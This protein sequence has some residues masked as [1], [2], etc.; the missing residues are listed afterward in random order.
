MPSLVNTPS[1]SMAA[2]PWPA[3]SRLSTADATRSRRSRRRLDQ[4]HVRRRRMVA[5]AL[6][7]EREGRLRDTVVG[8]GRRDTARGAGG[9]ARDP[10]RQVVG[11]AAGVHQQNS[12]QP[13]R[14]GGQQPF[15]QLDGSLLQVAAVG[16]ERGQLGAD[17]VD[18]RRV[19][20][21]QHGHVV[22]G[23]EVAAPVRPLE[24]HPSS[25]HEMHRLGVAE[26]EP[27]QQV[28]ACAKKL[29][30][31]SSAVGQP[32]TDV[33]CAPRAARRD[34]G[35]PSCQRVQADVEHGLELAVRLVADLR[36]EALLAGSA[37]R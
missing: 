32:A 15:G 5:P 31:G 29:R 27:A 1:T 17:R 37:R 14:E 4:P 19:R 11:L 28:R 18:D 33:W 20:V 25:T 8:P 23:I 35:E 24:E 10:P 26:L 22:V 13:S 9:M 30:R 2:T 36:R 16:V 34:G 7:R 12:V 3:A 21:S 6:R